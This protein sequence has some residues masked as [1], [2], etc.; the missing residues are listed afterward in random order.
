VTPAAA[1]PTVS[2]MK[3]QAKKQLDAILGAYDA[4]LAEVARVDEAKRAAQ[5]AFPARFAT[6]R[7]ETIRPAIQE[8]ADALNALGH[9]A[10]ANEQEESSSTAGGVT[11]ASVSLKIIPKPHARKPADAN[12]KS[13]IEIT[14]AANR[15][16]RK[17]VVSSTNTLINSSGSLGKR[18]EY[19]VDEV[20]GDVVAHHVLQALQEAFAGTR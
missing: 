4:K 11:S 6:A 3:D 14:F 2:G 15:A 1:R 18:G 10:T 8:F 19:E 9:E 17:V 12:K 16:E 20:T 5:A 7:T 13:F